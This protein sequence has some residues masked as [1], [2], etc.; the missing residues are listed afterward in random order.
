[1]VG[2]SVWAD[3]AL[4]WFTGERDDEAFIATVAGNFSLLVD[5]WLLRQKAILN[6]T[7]QHTQNI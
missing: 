4:Q 5:A 2:R 1:M 3:A 6:A 7:E